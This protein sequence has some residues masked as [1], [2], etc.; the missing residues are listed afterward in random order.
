MVAAVACP[1]SNKVG[2][3]HLLSASFRSVFELNP[4]MTTLHRPFF[5]TFQIPVS[6]VSRYFDAKTEYCL[7][8]VSLSEI[9]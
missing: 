9:T 8:L 5:L 4:A 6:I 2:R 7:L 1:G 3:L